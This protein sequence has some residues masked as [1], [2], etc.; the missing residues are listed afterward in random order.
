MTW[1]RTNHFL[2]ESIN[3]INITWLFSLQWIFRRF[4]VFK[5]DLTANS[6][7]LKYV[8]IEEIEAWCSRPLHRMIREALVPQGAGLAAAW[9][10]ESLWHQ[11][12]VFL[13]VTIRTE[14]AFFKSLLDPITC[15][16][17]FRRFSFSTKWFYTIKLQILPSFLLYLPC[18]YK[19]IGMVQSCRWCPPDGLPL[20]LICMCSQIV[21]GREN[22]CLLTSMA[23]RTPESHTLCSLPVKLWHPH[24]GDV[25]H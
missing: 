17:L 15:D 13:C 25:I 22:R 8:E 3:S 2:P 20:Y 4:G 24:T 7:N 1:F 6:T 11:C 14:A 12:E 10:A 23:S 18:P 19:F 21:S 5:H 9:D 16:F